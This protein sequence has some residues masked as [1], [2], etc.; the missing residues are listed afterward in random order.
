MTLEMSSFIVKTEDE[1]LMKFSPMVFF[2]VE[3]RSDHNTICKF[4]TG[5]VLLCFLTFQDGIKFDENLLKEKK[6][7][8]KI[9]K[10]D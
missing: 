9:G 8:I 1:K 4:T 5:Q 10:K 6:I 7:S 2:Q 3:I